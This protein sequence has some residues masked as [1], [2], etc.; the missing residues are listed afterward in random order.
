MMAHALYHASADSRIP[1][2]LRVVLS[3]V[4]PHELPSGPPGA[5]QSSQG[6]GR[7]VARS[8]H[9]TWGNDARKG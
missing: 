6:L 2:R 1:V 7:R 5:G 3:R 4:Q 9:T 8:E